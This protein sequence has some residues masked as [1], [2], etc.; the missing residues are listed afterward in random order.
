MA[1]GQKIAKTVVDRRSQIPLVHWIKSKLFGVYRQDITPPPGPY[2]ADGKCV[3]RDPNRYVDEMS[4]RDQ[5]P[6][7]LPPG[8]NHRLSGVAYFERDARR[9]VTPPLVVYDFDSKVGKRFVFYN[10]DESFINKGPDNNFGL[11]APTPGTGLEWRR[12]KAE[13]LNTQKRSEFLDY[14]E[15]FDRY[16]KAH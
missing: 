7:K 6:P 3:F 8:V 13:E 10:T 11:N 5:P 2:T 16:A 4:A 9:S 1:S 15:K 12:N 14:L